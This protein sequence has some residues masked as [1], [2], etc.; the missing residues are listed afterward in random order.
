MYLVLFEDE[1]QPLILHNVDPSKYDRAK[2]LVNPILPRGI[3]P[4]RWRKG[5]NC[6]EIIP[7]V[8]ALRGPVEPKAKDLPTPLKRSRFITKQIILIVLLNAI[9]SLIIKVL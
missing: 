7:E 4:H 9:I 5:K 6:I 1:K 3:P 2:I 8:E